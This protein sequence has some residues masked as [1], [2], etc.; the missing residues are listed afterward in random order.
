[1]LHM[2]HLVLPPAAFE[3]SAREEPHMTLLAIELAAS[4]VAASAWAASASAA[5][6]IASWAWKWAMS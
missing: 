3:V 6:N 4:V 5:S 1:M 2:A